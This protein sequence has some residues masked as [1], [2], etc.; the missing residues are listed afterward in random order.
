MNSSMRADWVAD[1]G[2]A[3]RRCCDL[4]YSTCMPA[5]HVGRKDYAPCFLLGDLPTAVPGPGLRICALRARLWRAR[6]RARARRHVSRE[7]DRFYRLQSAIMRNGCQT[8]CARVSGPSQKERLRR[9]ALRKYCDAKELSYRCRMVPS[10]SASIAESPS[11]RT[12]GSLNWQHK[13]GSLPVE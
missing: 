10:C 5:M 2:A 9:A 6:D 12:F 8:N 7:P 13:K 4:G 1:V 3:D 11:I